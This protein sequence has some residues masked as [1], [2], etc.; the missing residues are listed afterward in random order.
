MCF[1]RCC[2]TIQRYVT[3]SNKSMFFMGIFNWHYSEGILGVW[4]M[5]VRLLHFFWRFFNIF[6]L[7][8]TLLAPWKRDVAFK[9]WRGFNLALLLRLISDNVF[10]RMMGAIARFGVIFFG[11]VF[12]AAYSALFLIFFLIW[13]TLPIALPASLIWFVFDQAVIS[14]C[15]VALSLFVLFLSFY[16]HWVASLP[17]Y[18]SLNLEQL[19]VYPWFHR[20]YDRLGVMAKEV[21]P[22]MFQNQALLQNFLKTHYVT[23]DEFSRIVEK[24]IAEQIHLERAHFFWE[25]ERLDKVTPI[26]YSWDFAYTAHLD[27]YCADLSEGGGSSLDDKKTDGHIESYKKMLVALARPSQ[28]SVL[29]TGNAG[30]GRMAMVYS[31]ARAV[32]QQQFSGTVLGRKRVLLFNPSEAIVRA[33]NNGLSVDGFLRSLFSEAAYAGNVILVIQDIAHYVSGRDG[34][35]AVNIAS[36]LSEFLEHPTFQIIG[37]ASSQDFHD[38]LSR[39]QLIMKSFD[40]VDVEEVSKEFSMDILIERYRGVENRR[41]IFSYQA[42]RSIVDLSEQ[43]NPSI[44]LPE[45]ALDLAEQTMLYWQKGGGVDVMMPNVVEEYITFKTGIPVGAPSDEEREKLLNL[46]TILHSRIVGQEEAVVQVAEAVRKM[47][48]GVHDSK[49]PIGSFLF[50]GPTGVGKTETAKALAESYFGNENAMIRLD[51]S[52]FQGSGALDRFIGSR[53]LNTRGRIVSAVKD[54]PYSLLLLD[55]IE[56]ADPRVLD[57]FLQILDEGFLT[58]VF[59]ERVLFRNMVIIATSNAGALT[60]RALIEQGVAYDVMRRTIIDEVTASGMFRL[61]FLNRFNGVILF[62]PLNYG[63]LEQ[64][65]RFIL[66]RIARSIF[67]EKNIQIFFEEACVQTVVERGYESIFG[68]RSVRRYVETHIENL[69]AQKLLS[70]EVVEGGT[71]TIRAEEL[72]G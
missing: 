66:E 26:G 5:G 8:R 3:V 45:R 27:A 29:L 28:N 65:T 35:N 48:S 42:L 25:Q 53:E 19:R 17:D 23:E 71:L 34:S 13:I 59:G 52:E 51:M 50:L 54:H 9:Y 24:E 33:E 7:F 41:V 4:E 18:F 31:F 61:E 40:K 37:T 10:A 43:F 22:G 69:I 2:C 36:V 20:V 55:E 49:K 30:V 21:D 6:P 58:D 47:R 60:L 39:N 32:R 16:G 11:L 46:E 72:G 1:A 14:F 57:L 12:I 68:A 15:V 38:H 63:E 62:R 56:K 64:V 67:S 44:P 70:R